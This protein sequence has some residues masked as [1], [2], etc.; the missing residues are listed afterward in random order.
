METRKKF[1]QKETKLAWIAVRNLAV[2]WD[3]AQRKYRPAWAKEIAEN[4][5]PEKFYPVKVMQPNCN[6]ICH[7]CEGQHRVGAVR[8]LWGDD[9]LVPCLMALTSDRARAAEIFL[10]DSADRHNVDK[11][12]KFRISV[13]AERPEAV[14]INKIVRH[15]GYR[16]DGSHA[17]DCIAAVDA[18]GYVYR[19]GAKTLD[20]TLH[21]LRQTWGGDAAGVSASMI[22]SYG[23]FVC[24]FY[25]RID[26]K[27]LCDVVQKAWHSPARFIDNVKAHKDTARLNTLTEAAEQL[28]LRAYNRGLRDDKKL[29]RKKREEDDE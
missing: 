21:V 14:A 20:R 27:R 28:L 6:G 25:E 26:Q 15:C 5:D 11:I 12:S 16:V 17:Q 18:L 9:E 2:I 24:E 7:I 10:G 23:A 29:R 8:T 3:D 22:R 4:F 19:K 1:N 13:T